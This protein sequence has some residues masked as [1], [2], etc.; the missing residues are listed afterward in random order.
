MPKALKFNGK[1]KILRSKLDYLLTNKLMPFREN[2]YQ[3]K[4]K[5]YPFVDGRMIPIFK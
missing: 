3:L 2:S 1:K 5:Q 4:N